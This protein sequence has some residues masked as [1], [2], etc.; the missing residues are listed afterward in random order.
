MKRAKEKKMRVE[1][2]L[3]D[4][5]I[6][7]N[8]RNIH[9]LP[10]K[11]KVIDDLGMEFKVHRNFV[12]S[13]NTGQITF[14]SFEVF[15]SLVL[16]R[17]MNQNIERRMMS[18]GEVVFGKDCFLPFVIISSGPKDG[19]FHFRAT[20]MRTN[21]YTDLPEHDRDTILEGLGE[22]VLCCVSSHFND[23]LPVDITVN[24]YIEKPEG[25]TDYPE[26]IGVF[27]LMDEVHA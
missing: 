27:V 18:V 9:F 24:T 6:P 1:K 22:Y 15:D 8:V 26:S 25:A 10:Q 20:M 4:R 13:P 3:Q 14:T 7:S 16:S 17:Q 2:K 21:G 5:C 12:F 11:A 19:G 23:K